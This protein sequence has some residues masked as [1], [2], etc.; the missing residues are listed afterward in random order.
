MQCDRPRSC[1]DRFDVLEEDEV[2]R[3]RAALLLITL[4]CVFTGSFVAYWLTAAHQ[5]SDL[6]GITVDGG[7]SRGFSRPE[8]AL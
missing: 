6:L 7:R 8:D 5:K 4:F 2:K 3:D 1:S